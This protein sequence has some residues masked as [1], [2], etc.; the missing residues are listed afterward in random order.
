MIEKISL[1]PNKASDTF[2]DHDGHTFFRKEVRAVCPHDT[3]EKMMMQV[4]KTNF[5][6]QRLFDAIRSI[7]MCLHQPSRWSWDALKSRYVG[8]QNCAEAVYEPL[9][10]L[11]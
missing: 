6:M 10:M 2:T 1:N 3:Q 4:Q 9:R 5:A 11:S 7:G 8:K